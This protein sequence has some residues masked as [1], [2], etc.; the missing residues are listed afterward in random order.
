MQVVLPHGWHG[1]RRGVVVH[2][3]RAFVCH[4]LPELHT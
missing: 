4:G 3:G 1:W 2:G